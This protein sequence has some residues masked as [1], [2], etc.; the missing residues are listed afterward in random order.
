ML[1]IFIDDE[2]HPK[3]ENFD[4]IVRTKE[5]LFKL[6]KENPDKLISYISF[7]H[8][9]GTGQP[10]GY[11]IAKQLVVRDTF[12]GVFAEDFTFNVHSA[13][14]VGAENIQCYLESY[15]EF[16]RENNV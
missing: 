12:K 9:L 15:L 6:L 14:P 3:V 1:R 10:T 11:D 8:D 4:H 7:D 16:K 2:R 5:D 13:N